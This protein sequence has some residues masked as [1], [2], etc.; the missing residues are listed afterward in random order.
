MVKIMRKKMIINRV[1]KIK[2]IFKVNTQKIRENLLTKLYEL[3]VLAQGQAKNDRL[4]LQDRQEWLRIA[5]YC[6]QVIN[7]LTKSF[8]EAKI[9]KDLEKLEKLINEAMA[10]EKDR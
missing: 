5:A 10:K 3:F 1:Q 9:T 4:E 8:D 2:R 7:G 6:G